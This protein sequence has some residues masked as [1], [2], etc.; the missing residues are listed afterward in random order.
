MSDDP[1]AGDDE[2]AATPADIFEA[3]DPAE[4]DADEEAAVWEE[5]EGDGAAEDGDLF[6]RLAEENPTDQLAGELET[7]GDT[8]VVPKKRFCQRCEHF[9]APPEVRCGHPGTTIEEM[10]DGERFRVRNCPVVEERQGASDVLD[11]E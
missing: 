3:V 2:E 8:T 1:S 4:L 10:V 9:S 6:E 7:E 11:A 5:L